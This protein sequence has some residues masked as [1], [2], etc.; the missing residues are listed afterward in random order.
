M[1]VESFAVEESLK[2]ETLLLPP[3]LDLGVKDGMVGQGLAP[4][5]LHG[6]ALLPLHH[7]DVIQGFRDRAGAEIL[8]QDAALA[9]PTPGQVALGAPLLPIGH[10]CYLLPAAP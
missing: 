3:A 6:L 1:A 8:S 7:L 2:Q 10:V 4:G 9:F 5:I